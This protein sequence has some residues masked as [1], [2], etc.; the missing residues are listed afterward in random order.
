MR[1]SEQVAI[2]VVIIH[3]TNNKTPN[4]MKKL[5]FL[6]ATVGMIFTACQSGS[7]DDGSNGGN[8]NGGGEVYDPN[9]PLSNQKCSNNELLYISKSCLPMELSTYD[10]WGAKLISNTYENGVGRLT[11][12]GEIT[13]IPE[14]AFYENE[15]LEFFKMPKSVTSIGRYAF[16][17]CTSLTSI[18]IP[19]SVTSIGDGAFYDCT[20][21]KAFYGKFASTDN[22]CLIVNGVLKVF[23]IGCGATEY[24]IPDSVTSIGVAAFYYCRSLTAFHSKFASADNRC[25]IVDGVLNSFAPAGLTQYTIPDSVTSIGKSAFYG[26][27]KLTS[28]TIP[29]SVTSIGKSAFYGCSKLT[30]ITIPDSVTSIGYEAFYECSSLTSVTIGNSVTSIGDYAFSYCTSLTSV[31]I[32]NSVTSIGDYAFYKCSSLTSVTIPNSVTS[33]GDYAFY[34]CTSLK[35]V[36]IPN[37]VT[38]IG[39]N[40]FC[41]CSSLTSVTIPNSVT[42]IG[43]RA[44][45][46]C[47]S[48]TSVTIPNSVTSIGDYAFYECSSLTSVYCKPTTPPTGGN[49]MFPYYSNGYYKPLVCSIYVPRDSVEVYKSA[50]YWVNYALSIG[51]YDF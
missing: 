23:A 33:I 9:N 20:S 17:D 39:E 42:S 1:L 28:I 5:L 22:C 11:F 26:C 43:Y 2:F 40:A 24:T 10:G 6:L 7:L 50:D 27:S 36:T 37:S 3:R 32:G 14:N 47:K 12:N 31:T 13:T 21:L 44:F 15:L 38:S 18:T 25:L 41:C 16:G 19:D 29:D 51:G 8:G 49:N 34:G 35:S 48:L 45:Y 46:I 4:N 30:S